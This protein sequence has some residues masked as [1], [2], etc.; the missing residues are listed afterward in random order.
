[1]AESKIDYSDVVQQLR[2]TFRQGKTLPVWYRIGQLKQ[3]LKMMQDNKELF[4]EAL[5]QD[6]R[7]PKFESALMEH[8]VMVAEIMKFIS[9][10]PEW[11]NF[12]KTQPDLMNQM[13][14]CGIKY[15]PYG[16][17]LII[18]AWN[19][20][21]L[22][23]LQPLIGCIAAGN[24]AILKPS[25]LSPATASLVE[26]LLPRYLDEDCYRI[27]QG[28]KDETTALL[29]ERFDFI[30][31][32]GGH[33]VGKIVM[34]AAAQY[35][36]PVALELGG[37]SPCFVDNDCNFDVT[38]RRIMWGKFVN[39]GQTC[40][41]PDYILCSEEAEQKLIPSIRSAM[42]EF[43]G[44]N[45]KDSPDLARVVNDRHF[46]RLESLID[47]S[48]V[49]IGG[50]TD[51]SQKYIAPT[52]MKGV[53]PS[54]P[55]MME[56]IF[57]PILPIVNVAGPTDAV[58]FIK[59][60]EKP[61][62]LY[63]FSKNQANIDKF[64]DETSSG[65]V[66]VNDAIVQAAVPSLPFGGVGQSGMGAYH[67]KFSFECFSHR[68]AC[69]IKKQNLEALNAM[70]YPPYNETNLRRAVWFLTP[71]KNKYNKYFFYFALL[72]ALA[73]L[74]KYCGIFSMLQ[75]K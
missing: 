27:I 22:L 16:V 65:A 32:T 25:E 30:F 8:T 71:S 74:F 64:L 63:V 67:G 2:T 11:A 3:F 20:P 26:S 51:A 31:Y 41:A 14:T 9:N 29:R 33:V 12:Q 40:L 1:M 55:I 39:S 13:N 68:K 42:K 54:D 34:K 49:A 21:L 66:C 73:S 36:T 45:P 38:A 70:R 48:K 46:N 4:I 47:P 17:C 58:K 69:L 28:A 62:A 24:C 53:S 50:E 6:L 56:E 57:G 61:L 72:A 15:D 60:R 18:G 35:L 5:H 23:L 7:K 19:Y 44:E 43:Y 52:I 59:E 75:K 37:K 10:L